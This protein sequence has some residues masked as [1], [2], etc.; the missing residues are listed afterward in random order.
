MEFKE[1]DR[2]EVIQLPVTFRGRLLLNEA[3]IG[4][5]ATVVAE[6]V[7]SMGRHGED[8]MI[9]DFDTRQD[10]SNSWTVDRKCFALVPD[11]PTDDEINEVYR[12]L[13]VKRGIVSGLVSKL[14]R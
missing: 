3:E 11:P 6:T 7:E 5:Q 4:A 14:R 13:G 12:S 10:G 2:V 1:G 8:M 9:V